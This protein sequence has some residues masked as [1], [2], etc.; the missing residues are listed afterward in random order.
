MR[1][2]VLK[3]RNG[4]TIDMMSYN[5]ADLFATPV[6]RFTSRPATAGIE[7]YVYDLVKELNIPR[8]SNSIRDAKRKAGKIF[9]DFMEML[10]NDM[11]DEHVIFILPMPNG[12]Y[13]YITDLNTINWP[14]KRYFNP[15]TGGT[16][17]VPIIHRGTRLHYK[18]AAQYTVR[19]NQKL[20]IKL[21]KKVLEGERYID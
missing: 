12:G 17:N 15:A 8:H 18:R 1:A 3:Y 2:K 20:R 5:A 11:I 7:P 16:Y 14:E 10:G 21:F 9:E 6:R 19:F 4:D 13:L